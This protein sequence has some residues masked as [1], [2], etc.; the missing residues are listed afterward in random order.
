MQSPL[1]ATHINHFGQ[2]RGFICVGEALKVPDRCG[3]AG[4]YMLL[5]VL[6]L[7]TPF[8]L[9]ERR[10][11]IAPGVAQVLKYIGQGFEAAAD[12][13]A[14]ED[15]E[16]MGNDGSA[17]Y[18]TIS[19]VLHT[20]C[21]V[22]GL[23]WSLSNVSNV[24]APLQRQLVLRLLRSGHFTRQLA[25]VK[26][27]FLLLTRA[28]RVDSTIREEA[29]A[30]LKNVQAG[31]E[32]VENLVDG[33]GGGA[34]NQAAPPAPAAAGA[35]TAPAAGTS[36]GIKP[37]DIAIAGLGGLQALLDWI[38]AEKIVERMLRTNLH[39]PQYAEAAQR[40]LVP[41]ARHGVVTSEHL[42]FLWDLIE[43]TA[44]FEDIK[45]NV[46]AILGAVTP[47][48]PSEAQSAMLRRATAMAQGPSPA[49]L[50][51]ALRL[52]ESI[53]RND[54]DCVMPHE[55]LNTLCDIILRT[56]SPLET[57][58][59]TH[60]ADAC[61]RYRPHSK[62][63]TDHDWPH[64]VIQ[65]CAAALKSGKGGVPAA[66]QMFQAFAKVLPTYFPNDVSLN[67]LIYPYRFVHLICTDSCFFN[68][69]SF[70]K[71]AIECSF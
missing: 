20:C 10:I 37:V 61:L 17:V 63:G 16:E 32:A 36:W 56:E 55:V 31:G 28:L 6:N 41:L 66:C 49:A 42:S 19:G 8:L 22:G 3:L 60:L 2:A 57:A 58:T 71:E 64:L 35:G 1:V 45:H 52:L 48:L 46:C 69:I 14:F 34:S 44:T 38:R 21:Q 15:E 47:H 62:P 53:S 67:R 54:T 12:F 30:Q 39:Q 68:E 65:K 23:I 25:A 43:D 70:R 7:S 27:L 51:L 11:E 4:V 29:E 40:I 13:S 26:E 5:S 18:T 33:E 9:P 24:A 50:S 59:A